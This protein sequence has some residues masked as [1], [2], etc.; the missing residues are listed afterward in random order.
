MRKTRRD[1]DS[2]A[3]DDPP[4]APPARPA[5]DDCCRSGCDPCVFD[6]YNAALERYHAALA[7]WKA[8]HG[9]LD[10]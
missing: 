8:R 5:P 7:E 2:A 4:P 9:I 10:D 1:D 3:R 6:L